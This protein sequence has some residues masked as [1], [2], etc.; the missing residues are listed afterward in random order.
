LM[1]TLRRGDLL[2]WSTPIVPSASR[3]SPM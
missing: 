2:F 3:R 1:R